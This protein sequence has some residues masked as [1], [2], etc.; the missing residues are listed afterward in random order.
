MGDT[1]SPAAC[2]G[3]RGRGATWLVG[4]HCL[5]VGVFEFPHTAAPGRPPRVRAPYLAG[6]PTPHRRPASTHMRSLPE[7]QAAG[8]WRRLHTGC[9]PRGASPPPN[10]PRS[11]CQPATCPHAHSRPQ[12]APRNRARRTRGARSSKTHGVR[13]GAAKGS[14]GVSHHACGAARPPAAPNTPR[15]VLRVHMYRVHHPKLKLPGHL[16]C[17]RHCLG[18]P[19][20]SLDTGCPAVLEPRDTFVPDSRNVSPWTEKCSGTPKPLSEHPGTAFFAPEAGSHNA[21]A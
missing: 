13:C 18:H 17:P 7:G 2:T 21:Q 9:P 10:T 19:Q 1:T 4:W 8:G 12:T 16:N 14:A 20:L 11:N 15:R 5:A 3:W 6:A